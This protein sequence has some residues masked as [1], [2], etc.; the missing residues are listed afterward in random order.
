MDEWDIPINIHPFHQR[1][2]AVPQWEC[3]MNTAPGRR[4]TWHLKC[5]MLKVNCIR[6]MFRMVCHDQQVL[7][8]YAHRVAYMSVH[9]TQHVCTQCCS[10]KHAASNEGIILHLQTVPCIGVKC[11]TGGNTKIRPPFDHHLC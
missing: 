1:E 5:H 8:D 4:K 2:S 9:T 6:M 11:S 7:F 10:I 3:E